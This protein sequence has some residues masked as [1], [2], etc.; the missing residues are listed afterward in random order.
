LA[1]QTDGSATS[2]FARLTGWSSISW[3]ANVSLRSNGSRQ[4]FTQTGIVDSG[5]T[6]VSLNTGHAVEAIFSPLSLAARHSI[7]AGPSGC[8][9][10]ALL[11]IRTSNSILAGLTALS[12]CSLFAKGTGQSIASHGTLLAGGSIWSR[13]TNGSNESLVALHSLIGGLQ[14]WGQAVSWFTLLSGWTFEDVGKSVY[15]ASVALGS[16]ESRVSLLSRLAGES[17]VSL[18]AAI[19]I[20][21]GWT[22][23]AGGSWITPIAF[24][25]LGIDA[26]L[27]GLSGRTLLTRLSGR[28]TTSVHTGRS[29]RSLLAR[30]SVAAIDSA[31]SLGARLAAWSLDGSGSKI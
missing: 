28:T 22:P 12:G 6:S 15:V 1:S 9:F 16:L 18:A 4:R 29:D 24:G 23:G 7:Q 17:G 26:A 27:A 5:W 13:V 20:E 25:A 30:P 31:W 2:W 14:G 19:A 10:H 11:A 8:T 3:G 21:S